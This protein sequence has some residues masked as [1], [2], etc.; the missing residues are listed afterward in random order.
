MQYHHDPNARPPEP[1]ACQFPAGV[2]S[3][4][5][6]SRINNTFIPNRIIFTDNPGRSCV[7]SHNGEGAVKTRNLILLRGE[8]FALR[9]ANFD[10]QKRKGH[11]ATWAAFSFK[12]E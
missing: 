7:L 2:V 11:P 1:Y 12:G 9:T 6:S 5:R 3:D 10:S 8:V 4:D